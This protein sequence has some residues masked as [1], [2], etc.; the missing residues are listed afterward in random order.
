VEEDSI[1]VKGTSCDLLAMRYEL[2]PSKY[3]PTGAAI[4]GK[5]LLR[6]PEI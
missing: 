3:Y 1:A 5:D 2:L 4:T 6:K